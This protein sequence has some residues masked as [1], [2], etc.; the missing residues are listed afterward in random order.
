MKVSSLCAGAA[1]RARA[2]NE[3][4]ECSEAMLLVV[5]E[6]GPTDLVNATDSS[7][8]LSAALV[9]EVPYATPVD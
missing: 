7:G 2:L 3:D 6:F 9:C 1:K 5:C 4:R 8:C